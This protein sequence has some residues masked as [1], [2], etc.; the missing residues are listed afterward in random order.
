MWMFCGQGGLGE[1]NK[2]FLNIHEDGD[3]VTMHPMNSD[4]AINIYSS[5]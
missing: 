4:G 5:V 1:R 2:A 3:A